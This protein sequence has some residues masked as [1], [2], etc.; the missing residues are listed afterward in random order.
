M[1]RTLSRVRVIPV[2]I[3]AACAVALGACGSSS[4]SSVGASGASVLRQTFTG[5]HKIDS[6]KI[7]LSL[8]VTPSGSSVVSGPISL[9]VSGPFQSLGAGKLP[10]LDLTATV[11]ALGQSGSIGV[12]STG[13]NGYLTLEGGNYAIPAGSY[14]K[15]QASVSHAGSH[16]MKHSASD[17]LGKLGIHPLDWL[18]NPTVVNAAAPVGGVQTTQVHTGVNVAALVRELYAAVISRAGTLRLAGAGK[19]PATIPTATLAKLA[20]IHPTID[21]WTG[22]SDHTLRKLMLQMSVPVSGQL[23]SRVGGVT[24]A[25][26][27]FT[28]QYNDVNQQQTITAPADVQPY[29]AFQAKLKSVLS[30]IGSLIGMSSLG[31]SLGSATGSS[32]SSAASGTAGKVSHYSKCIKAAGE[33]VTKMQKCSRLL[34]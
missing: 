27:T 32:S 26:L 11:S 21:V 25:Q 22:N 12:I 17:T 8:A 10:E 15:L 16:E 31:S 34:R 9:T 7:S 24:G 30:G 13:T 3:A 18:V 33:D 14:A 19:L 28:L 4:N 1:R 6:G 20:A 29:S 23:S 5:S 2:L